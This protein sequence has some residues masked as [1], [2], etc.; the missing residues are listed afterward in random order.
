MEHSSSMTAEQ[1]EP[2]RRC[3][4]GVGHFGHLS[5]SDLDA[6]LVVM[7][8]RR[9]LAGGVLIQQGEHGD[10]LFVLV[11]GCLAQWTKHG[12]FSPK[13]TGLFQPYCVLGSEAMNPKNSLRLHSVIA[14][15]DSQCWV[16]YRRIYENVLHTIHTGRKKT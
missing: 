13:K 15:T 4:Q 1:I 6:L 16:L 14:E 12:F 3:L 11:S 9:V 7:Q 8:S 5:E 10:A 2:I